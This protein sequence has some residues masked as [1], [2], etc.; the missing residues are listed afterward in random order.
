MIICAR[1]ST[2]SPKFLPF[3]RFNSGATSPKILPFQFQN[4]WKH[5]KCLRCYS[6]KHRAIQCPYFT[7]PTTTPCQYC[8]YL[9]HNDE[10]CPYFP[11]MYTVETSQDTEDINLDPAPIKLVWKMMVLLEMTKLVIAKLPDDPPTDTLTLLAVEKPAGG[12][13]NDSAPSADSDGY[14]TSPITIG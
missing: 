12:E 14:Q 11:K 9:Y 8:W 13:K 5:K 6:D 1:S 2:T 10:A 4:V 7:T 3:Q